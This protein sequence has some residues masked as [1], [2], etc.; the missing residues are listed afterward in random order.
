MMELEL[1][2]TGIWNVFLCVNRDKQN[3]TKTSNRETNQALQTLPKVGIDVS[4]Y[5]LVHT[6]IKLVSSFVMMV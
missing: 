3:I 1:N 6:V 4:S 2:Q 5:V